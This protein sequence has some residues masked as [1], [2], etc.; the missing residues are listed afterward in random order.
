MDEPFKILA[1][2]LCGMSVEQFE[3]EV[4]QWLDTARHS[5]WK[6]PYTELTYKPMIEV[7]NYM[8]A[9]GYKT[10][11]VTGGGQDF[12]RV[13]SEKTYGIP[14]EQIVGTAGGISFGYDKDGR[15]VLTKAPK[16]LLKR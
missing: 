8:R 2:T 7:L 4:K 6:R 13:Y 14:P 11:I 5:R 15:P 16:L 1:A 10:Y 12:V 9:N 3:A